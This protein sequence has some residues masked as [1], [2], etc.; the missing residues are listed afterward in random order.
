M[1]CCNGECGYMNLLKTYR[2]FCILFLLS[3]ACDGVFAEA[4]DQPNVLSEM[5]LD[6]L[7]N[8]KINS[9]SK[10]AQTVSEAPS[11][12]TIITSQDI[13][14]YGYETLADVFNAVRGFY[15]SNDRNY[16]Y[17]GVR[18]FSRP[19]DY[20]NRILLQING[21]VIN[22][23]IF[24]SAF[25][26]NT[27]PVRPEAIERIEIIRGPG[28]A[29]Y[30]TNAMFAVVNVVTKT[31][32]TVDGVSITPEIG[33]YG[34]TGAS[35]AFGAELKNG[36]DFMASGVWGDREGDDFYYR[37]FD[38]PATNNG[39]S[40]RND[41]EKFNSMLANAVY[42]NFSLFGFYSSRDKDIPTAP[43]GTDFNGV[44]MRTTDE[45]ISLALTYDKKISINREFK[46]RMF[47]NRYDYTSN[48][49]YLNDQSIESIYFD[50]ALG[51]MLGAEAQFTFDTG[52]NNRMIAGAE[53][54]DN[55]KT[56]YKYWDKNSAMYEEDSPFA[57][58]SLYLQD[59][60]QIAENLS[61]TL[62]VRG[63]KYGSYKVNC[64]PRLA[65]IYDPTRS[66]TFK[67]IYGIAFRGPNV[68][69]SG[70][71]EAGYWKRNEDLS[72]EKIFTT[73]FI[74]EKRLSDNL[75][76][77]ASTYYYRMNNMI[78]TEYDVTDDLYYYDNRSKNDALGLEIGLDARYDNSQN[79][80][81][82]Y[83][84][85]KTEDTSTN[86]RLTNSPAH[87]VKCGLTYPIIKNCIAGTEV[88]Y[89]STRKTV[90]GTSTDDYVM[91]NIHL[92]TGMLREHVR[93]SLYILNVFDV[94]YSLPGGFEHIQDSIRQDGRNYR[95]NISFKF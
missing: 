68:Y 58:S 12:V 81:L 87:L 18:G 9:A 61:A 19:T 51:E 25:I 83:A 34:R 5:S 94:A 52:P 59:I 62:G 90:Y 38:D 50:S 31:G 56:Q 49:P 77:T 10:Y 40:K 39:I 60:Y 45:M 88:R 71:E 3:I 1:Y 91:T 7:L 24:G 41:G 35:A 84:L 66:D 2:K 82:N 36:L 69:E 30:G 86:T 6:S 67:F 13:E 15:T 78:D 27:L 14:N 95:V 92:S 4:G 53:Y 26:D 80:Y 33:S 73:E 63:D 93:V 65:F 75:M 72:T 43:W 55:L 20:N 32:N 11:S 54:R 29:L 47:Y 64:S 89:E 85:Q 79:Y 23:N 74:W 70:Y 57:V 46:I 22:E 28:S 8:I 37:E 17:V 48:Y 21:H 44:S 42:K 76:S 16:G